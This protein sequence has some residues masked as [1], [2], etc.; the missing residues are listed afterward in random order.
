MSLPEDQQVENVASSFYYT[1]EMLPADSAPRIWLDESAANT[2][3]NAKNGLLN[4]SGRK[5]IFS[6]YKIYNED[7]GETFYGDGTATDMARGIGSA[8]LFD[9]ERYL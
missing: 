5:T 9:L 8:N 6:V 4:T 2:F 3:A 7:G 1:S